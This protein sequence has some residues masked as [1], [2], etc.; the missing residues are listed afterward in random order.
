MSADYISHNRKGAHLRAKG[1]KTPK[2]KNKPKKKKS[3]ASFI[4]VSTSCQDSKPSGWSNF[5]MIF[6]FFLQL[7]LFEKPLLFTSVSH[8]QIAT[9]QL[10]STN[11]CTHP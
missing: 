4:V 9:A 8:I 7:F 10:P 2:K 5:K 6:F 11:A 3:T 1:E